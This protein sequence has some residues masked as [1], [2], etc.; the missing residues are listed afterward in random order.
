MSFQAFPEPAPDGPRLAVVLK[1]YPR[2]SETFIAHELAALERLGLRLLVVSLRQPTDALRHPVHARV[3][4]PA[5]YLPEYLWREPRR[6]AAGVLGACRRFGP[7]TRR[8]LGQWLRDLR[9]DPTP[10]RVRRFGQAAVLAT[11]LPPRIRHLHAHFL[12]TPAS[13]ARYAALIT[14]RS[15]SLAAHAK[16]VWTTPAWELREKLRDAR[17]CVTCTR[18]ARDYLAPL[19]GPTPLYLHYHGLDRTLF[20]RPEGVG[21]GRDGRDPGDPVRLLSV[22]RFH[23]KKGFD[24]LLR[25]LARVPGHVHLTLVGYGPEERRLRA[26]ARRLGLD[27]RLRWTGPLDQPAVR[28]LYRS[29]DLFVLAPR[30]VP[31]GDRDGLPNVV[32]EALSQGLPVV[33][34]RVGGIPEVVEDGVTGRLVAPDD[35]DG[36]ARVLAALAADPGARQRLARAALDRL[37]HPEF[38]LEATA[39]A[40]AALLAATLAAAP[41]P[42]AARGGDGRLA[43]RPA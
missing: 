43:A 35:P 40:L 2:L 27:A 30:V 25:A 4:A 15:L 18:A 7:G 33:A 20:A 19:A 5:L 23:P 28:A 26:L 14:G 11:E 6:V 17:F 16:D 32:M 36:L 38:D 34:T 9:R 39:R 29:S 1:G 12:H 42:G 24:V 3:G 8:A 13:V 22:G 41:D 10:N 31:D 21:S 37:A